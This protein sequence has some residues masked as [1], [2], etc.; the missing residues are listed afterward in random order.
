MIKKG[1]KVSAI[2]LVYHNEKFLKNCV[3]SM[4]Q[5]AKI[6]NVDLEIIVVVNDTKLEKS[7]F[8]VPKNCTIIFN[9]K[10]LGFGKSINKASIVANGDWLL[11]AN[12]DTIAISDTLKILLT[13]VDD[14]KIG[15][16]APKVIN[17]NGSLQFSILDRPTL[18]NIFKEQ[19]YIYRLFPSVFHSTQVDKKIYEY[20]HEVDLVSGAYFLIKRD[21]FNRIGGF[22]ERFFI[23][24][25]DFDLCKRVR[26]FGYKIIF[27]S[28]TKITHFGHQSNQGIVI[29]S[30][31]IESLYKYLR[32]YYS[33]NYALLGISLVALG[34]FFRLIYWFFRTKF[35]F[36]EDI[37]DF[38]RKKIVYCREVLKSYPKFL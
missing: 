8:L 7:G 2:I 36:S 22:D 32:K 19:T 24:F 17:P 21:V 12:L 35:T 5:S 20:F 10:N 13:H 16:I 18:W 26:K 11:I 25:E 37:K 23:Y 4:R 15:I 28:R 31:Y 34:S 30:I 6:A 9:K 3:L 33:S 38:G 27:E 1:P 14:E 29:G